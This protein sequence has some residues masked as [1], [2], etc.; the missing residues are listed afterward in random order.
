MQRWFFGQAQHQMEGKTEALQPTGENFLLHIFRRYPKNFFS[1][2]LA[3]ALL[4][5]SNLSLIPIGTDMNFQTWR[6]TPVER[7][8][9]CRKTRRSF[10][11][12]SR[13]RFPTPTAMFAALLAA[14]CRRGCSTT[15]GLQ[16]RAG[17]ESDE[18][19]HHIQSRTHVVRLS[20]SPAPRSYSRMGSVV[21]RYGG[22]ACAVS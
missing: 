9:S 18:Q 21:V 20:E 3:C 19:R 11:I 7:R 13:G 4:T 22:I 6:M 14:P 17:P 8:P 16:L 2:S 5:L 15:S 1:L 12:R 10:V